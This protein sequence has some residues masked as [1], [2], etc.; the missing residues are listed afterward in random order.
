M[1]SAPLQPQQGK[2]RGFLNGDNTGG[3]RKW[4]GEEANGD[5]DR[6][7]WVRVGQGRGT[8]GGLR[9]KVMGSC[10]EYA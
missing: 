2:G 7:E 6:E 4:Q 3:E 8:G 10:S 5:G 1:A 9:L